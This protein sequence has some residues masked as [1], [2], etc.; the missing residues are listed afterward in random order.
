MDLTAHDDLP[1]SL[2]LTCIMPPLRSIFVCF[3]CGN[4]VAGLGCY[5]HHCKACVRASR[6]LRQFGPYRAFG[7]R[8]PSFSYCGELSFVS[9]GNLK[10]TE[11]AYC[12]QQQAF[13]LYKNRQLMKKTM[14]CLMRWSRLLLIF[15]S[16]HYQTS[17]W[18]QASSNLR[19]SEIDAD[20][21]I[22][23]LTFL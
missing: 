1:L 23:C 11:C 19:I 9:F 16:R 6:T 7:S 10:W 2:P 13:A 17:A 21:T 8:M 15:R 14:I 5:Q 3:N 20:L 4:F 22:Y 12:D 18:R